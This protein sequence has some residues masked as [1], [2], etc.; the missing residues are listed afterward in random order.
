MVRDGY[1][2]KWFLNISLRKLFWIFK[3][4]GNQHFSG[5]A[6]GTQLMIAGANSLWC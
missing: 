1:Q 4:N 2:G 6:C 5:R 3:G